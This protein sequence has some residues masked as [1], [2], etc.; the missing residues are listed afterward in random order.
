MKAL[1]FTLETPSPSLRVYGNGVLSFMNGVAMIDDGNMA[2]SNE[3]ETKAD[4]P[5]PKENGPEANAPKPNEDETEANMSKPNEDA[6]EA[7]MSNPNDNAP[8]TNRTEPNE[9]ALSPKS[10]IATGIYEDLVD[11]MI[12]DVASDYHRIRK[13]GL[14]DFDYLEEQ[15]KEMR[16]S[17]EANEKLN[18]HTKKGTKDKVDIF[19]QTGVNLVS[20]KDVIQCMHCGA[21]VVAGFFAPHL[22]RCM[23]GKGSPARHSAT[24]RST[25]AQNSSNPVS[26]KPKTSGSIREKKISNAKPDAADVENRKDVAGSKRRSTG[27]MKSLPSSSTSAKKSSKAKPDAAEEE[28]LEDVTA[29]KSSKAKPEDADQENLEYVTDSRRITRSM[30]LPSGSKSTKKSLHAKPDDADEENLKDVKGSRRITRSITLPA[31]SKSAKKSSNQKTD[32]ADEGNIRN[33]TGLKR[34]ARKLKK[35]KI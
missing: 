21:Q 26:K 31:G 30:T 19:G 3:E 17:C 14:E 4:N 23:K 35:P 25:T 28:N 34:S 12:V 16:L 24:I 9:D 13:L 29:K 6:P 22:D 1:H 27:T 18:G 33:V 7:D 8:E 20:T 11:S 5:K 32:D 2:K 10:K 15:E